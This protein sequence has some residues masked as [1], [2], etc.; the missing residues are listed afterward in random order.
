MVDILVPTALFAGV[1]ATVFFAFLSI[2]HSVN[3]RANARVRGLSEQLDRAGIRLGSQEIV[4]TVCAGIA[5]VWIA[6]ALVLHPSLLFALLLLVGLAA[7]AFFGF[8]G[9]VAVCI[10][11]RLDAFVTQLEPAARLIAGG[12]RVGLGTRQALAI[13]IEELPDPARHEFKRV[14]G[15]TNLG[16][17][18]FDA[19]DDLAERM[20]SPESKMLARVFRVQSETGGDLARILDQLGETIKARRQVQRKTSS[21]TAEGRMSAWVLM[22]IPVFLGVFIASTQP[23][24]ANALTATFV[25]RMVLLIVL[26][27][28]VAAYFS[29]KAVMRIDV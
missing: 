27:L 8:S 6:L 5:V 9:F 2:W 14:I 28:E 21:L 18:I 12:L 17:S 4:L 23:T 1:T 7:L 10:R 26:G 19:I 16:A 24:M 15:Q 11:R 3:E 29:L 13:V 25:G 22:A 20:P